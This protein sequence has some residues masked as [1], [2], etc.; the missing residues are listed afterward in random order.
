MSTQVTS[1]GVPAVVRNSGNCA[2]AVTVKGFAEKPLQ[3][4]HFRIIFLAFALS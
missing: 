3:T 1:N 4:L 2:V